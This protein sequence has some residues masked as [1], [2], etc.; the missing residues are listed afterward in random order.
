VRF[1]EF[2]PRSYEIVVTAPQTVIPPET[3][4]S[5]SDTEELLHI[6]IE[7][8]E[9]TSKRRKMYLLAWMAMKELEQK[10]PTTEEWE[11]CR[12]AYAL[13]KKIASKDYQLNQLKGTGKSTESFVQIES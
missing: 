8:P 5:I 4:H 10:P 1:N 7:A 3:Y 6:P 11:I 9:V 2:K 13:L 12:R